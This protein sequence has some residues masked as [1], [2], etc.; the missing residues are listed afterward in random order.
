LNP[1][2][3]NR[4]RIGCEHVDQLLTEIE[5]IMNSGSS[6]VAFPQ[7]NTDISQIQQQCIEDYVTQIR[8][9]LIQVI[10]TLHIPPEHPKITVTKA[11]SA[12]MSAISISVDEL[13][14]SSMRGYG[15]ISPD[16]D[17]LLNGIV[18]EV[19]ALVKELHQFLTGT[20]GRDITSRLSELQQRGKD[21]ALLSRIEEIVRETG[22]VEFR[23]QIASI[24][25]KIEESQF[26]I[27]IFG[28]VSSGKSSLLNTILQ[29][30]ILPVGVTP[31][32]A[33]PI[34]IRYGLESKADITFADLPRITV[35]VD[36]LFEYATEQENP[37]N[38]KR[39][40][41]ISISLPSPCLKDGIGF[42][43]TPGLGS[44][45]TAGAAETK[46]YLPNADL[47]VV[48]IDAGSTLTADDLS[49]IL[50][51]QNAAV[52][53]HVLISKADLVSDED[54]NRLIAYVSDQISAR[55]GVT[56]QVYPVSVQPSYKHLTY[57]WYETQILPLRHSAHR[58]K[59]QSIQR[60][61]GGLAEAVS[62][63]L[64]SRLN[65]PGKMSEEMQKRYQE[66]DEIL[67]D[68]NAAIEEARSAV[69]EAGER[70][71]QDLA[72][73]WDELIPALVDRIT[74]S[75]GYESQPED[76]I[77]QYIMK[78][79]QRESSKVLHHIQDLKTRLNQTVQRAGT[80]LEKEP[81][82]LSDQTIRDMPIFDPGDIAVTLTFTR[83]ANLLGRQYIEKS[84][85]D[86]VKTQIKAPLKTSFAVYS[87]HLVRWSEEQIID[88]GREYESIA[89]EYRGYTSRNLGGAGDD[90]DR[91][92]NIEHWLE[93]LNEPEKE[94][95]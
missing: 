17:H 54:R 59:E 23:G 18:G 26:E 33:L 90:P 3:A 85:F 36:H 75:N 76:L 21:T 89:S 15:D 4:F 41:K 11:V 32:T 44:L 94:R 92:H 34:H 27:A 74:Q 61:I 58:L 1:H 5:T 77:R 64:Q 88:L 87:R 69:V 8:S 13:R 30:N 22:L 37:S 35:G 10:K 52:P 57:L 81:C 84:V 63:M 25:D 45:A 80:L 50:T 95:E 53:V 83:Y 12:R 51:L 6:S 49:T 73:L 72:P 93:Y 91:A 7:Y 47:G 60:K 68:G 40:S 38:K 82:H 86:Q 16:T 39:V 78:F 9:R 67:R 66:V 71:F 46:A 20:G 42:V 79:A 31:V 29:E 43:D 2:Q 24:L 65:R 70:T 62:E 56:Y 48:L 14:P 55:S 19:Q 28:R